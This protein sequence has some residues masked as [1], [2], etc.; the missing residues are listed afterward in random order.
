MNKK[1]PIYGDGRAS[2]YALS[3]IYDPG[4]PLSSMQNIAAPTPRVNSLVI[5]DTIGEHNTLYVVYSVDPETRKCTLVPAKLM[6][7]VD[8]YDNQIVTYGNNIYMLYWRT[9]TM[10]V[11][12]RT[13]DTHARTGK[14]YY[15]RS[16]DAESG[17]TYRKVS[18]YTG[19][20]FSDGEYYE[21][22]S[23]T[24]WQLT[25][26]Q[27]ISVFGTKITQ[28]ALFRGSNLTE[29][30]DRS[31]VSDYYLNDLGQAIQ[32]TRIDFDQVTVQATDGSEEEYTT[33]VKIPKVCYSSSQIENNDVFCLAMY[34]AEGRV[35]AQIALL[36]HDMLSLS[37]LASRQWPI[38][39]FTV[40][41]NQYDPV[42]GKC[43]LVRGQRLDEL[44]FYPQI[45]YAN[46]DSIA[47]AAIDN[48]KLCIY[49]KDEIS[50]AVPGS[51]YKVLLKYYLSNTEGV[52]DADTRD[53]Q[54][55]ETGRFIYTYATVKII[56]A[57]ESSVSK[58]APIPVYNTVTGWEIVPVVYYRSRQ[59]PRCISGTNWLASG[60]DGT[61][62]QN[63]QVLKIRSYEQD[64]DSAIPTEFISSYSMTVYLPTNIQDDPKI[65][66]TFRDDPSMSNRTYGINS[67]SVPRP[68]LIRELDGT[69]AA[70]RHYIPRDV[71][72]NATMFLNAFYYQ[73]DPPVV[74]GE[75]AVR[76]PTHFQIRN[77]L[78]GSGTINVVTP[79]PIP[80]ADYGND[81]AITDDL[82]NSEQIPGTCIV[83][84]L[85]HGTGMAADAY[86]YLYGVPV[87]VIKTIVN[88]Q[89]GDWHD[90]LYC[91]YNG[92]NYILSP[93]GSDDNV[94]Y[95]RTWGNSAI[96]LKA[97]T[98]GTTSFTWALYN[99]SNQLISDGMSN[100]IGLP[101]DKW[102]DPSQV[103]WT[104]S[105]VSYMSRT[106]WPSIG[107]CREKLYIRVKKHNYQ[108]PY[109]GARDAINT[110]RKWA[111]LSDDNL[112]IGT[113]EIGQVPGS[114][115]RWFITITSGMSAGSYYCDQL[116]TGSSVE[117]PAEVTWK[118]DPN[119]T[120][121]SHTKPP[122][123]VVEPDAY[124]EGTKDMALSPEVQL[125]ATITGAQEVI[126][127]T[128][129]NFP[130]GLTVN[131]SSGK[132]TGTPRVSGEFVGTVEVSSTNSNPVTITVHFTINNSSSYRGILYAIINGVK[133]VFSYI[134]ERDAVNQ[135]RLWEDS[136]HQLRIDSIG[137]YDDPEG[138]WGW[139]IFKPD[140]DGIY[141]YK[142]PGVFWETYSV[143]DGNALSLEDL[144]TDPDRGGFYIEGAQ[145]RLTYLDRIEPSDITGPATITIDQTVG[146]QITPT[147]LPHTAGNGETCV[148]TEDP[149]HMLPGGIA[150]SN[151]VL[152]GAV[153]TSGTFTSVIKISA[154]GCPDAQCTVTFN[155]AD[156]IPCHRGPIYVI[157]RSSMTYKRYE[158]AKLNS[159]LPA[160]RTWQASDNTVI[161]Q[162]ND[163]SRY[164]WAFVN[165]AASSSPIIRSTTEMGPSSS[166]EPFEV[167]W[168]SSDLIYI[169]KNPTTIIQAEDTTIN[170]NKNTPIQA[171][172]LTISSSIGFVPPIAF[173]CT[174]VRGPA[175]INITRGG[176]ITGSISADGDQVMTVQ[177]EC[178]VVNIPAKV[179]TVTF[180]YMGGEV[181]QGPYYLYSDACNSKLIYTAAE[182]AVG[183]A[184]TWRDESKAYPSIWGSSSESQSGT[185]YQ[186]YITAPA[187]ESGTD[188][189]FSQPETTQKDPDQ[190]TFSNGYSRYLLLRSPVGINLASRSGGQPSNHY[191]ATTKTLT[192][193][194]GETVQMVATSTNTS[195]LTNSF[196]WPTI[197]PSTTSDPRRQYI[198]VTGDGA[199]T[200]VGGYSGSGDLEVQ[201]YHSQHPYINET[202]KIVI[203]I[204]APGPGTIT[205]EDVSINFT[206]GRQF[207]GQATAVCTNTP[208]S[209][210]WVGNNFPSGITISPSG[211]ISGSSTAINDFT[212][213]A[214]VT[215]TLNGQTS[216][217]TININFIHVEDTTFRGTLYAIVGG[218]ERELLYGANSDTTGFARHW[219]E[220]STGLSEGIGVQ[221]DDTNPN[222]WVVYWG[223]GGP[224]GWTA[225]LSDDAD[226][227]DQ[228]Y[229]NG[230]RVTTYRLQDLI[231][232]PG[233]P[234]ESIAYHPG[235]TLEDTLAAASRT[236][237]VASTNTSLLAN[238]F[239]WSGNLPEGFTINPTTGVI[240][241]S[242]T[243]SSTSSSLTGTITAT[244][245]VHSKVSKSWTIT[246][247]KTTS[248]SSTITCDNPYTIN[249]DTGAAISHTIVANDSG[250]GN[251]LTFEI[252]N[253]K[254]SEITMNQY[255]VV[256]GTFTTTETRTM[257]VRIHSST[258]S[259]QP[260]LD[261]AVWFVYSPTGSDWHGNLYVAGTGFYETMTVPATHSTTV[262]FER[263]WTNANNTA[264]IE[265]N[266][267]S[268]Q[269]VCSYN[270]TEVAWGSQAN[271]QYDPDSANWISEGFVIS[272]TP[273]EG[274]IIRATSSDYSGVSDASSFTYTPDTAGSVIIGFKSGDTN[275]LSHGMTYELL[276][277]PAS[278]SDTFS[279]EN[280]TPTSDRRTNPM[281]LRLN[282]NLADSA[283]DKTL[284]LRV[285]SFDFPYIYKDFTLSFRSDLLAPTSINATSPVTIN[286]APSSTIS[287]QLSATAN[288]PS[289]IRYIA[290]DSIEG[291]TLDENTGQISGRITTTTDQTMRI[292]VAAANRVGSF[293]APAAI[294]VTFHYVS[295]GVFRDPLYVFFNGTEYTLSYQGNIQTTGTSRGWLNMTERLS[296]GY[297]NGNWVLTQEGSP[298]ATATP[299]N[300]TDDPDALTWTNGYHIYRTPQS[301]LL[302][303]SNKTINYND[304][305]S[306]EQSNSSDA[307]RQ[308]NVTHLN[309]SLI[310]NTWSYTSS[311]IPT[312]VTLNASTG[313][314]TGRVSSSTN[315]TFT[316]L[317]TNTSDG[318]IKKT[319]TVTLC[320]SPNGG[321]VIDITPPQTINY[322]SNDSVDASVLASDTAGAPVTLS[323]SGVPSGLTFSSN[324]GSGEISGRLTG[325]SDYTVTI[326]ATRGW[327][328]GQQTATTTVTFHNV[329]EPII[330]ETNYSDITF[331]RKGSSN[332]YTLTYVPG[333]DW[334][335]NH[336]IARR[337]W[338]ANPSTQEYYELYGQNVAM[339]GDCV[340]TLEHGG[341]VDD[342]KQGG[343]ID[344]TTAPCDSP[345]GPPDA[346][347]PDTTFEFI[348]WIAH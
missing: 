190:T 184:R 245:T 29:A 319:C 315:I 338:F 51:E 181:Y 213:T 276:T 147:V 60:F 299:V 281:I 314:I 12:E 236:A 243:G 46:G 36:A 182:T 303:F 188:I 119:V 269:W 347:W 225:A 39:S 20:S 1:V 302:T 76:T 341:W 221:K 101:G 328:G 65:L 35:V 267:G 98:S 179:I 160:E 114:G 219:E 242:Y 70:I 337:W 96:K 308:V 166:L 102:R 116:L 250:S 336:P 77:P 239:T 135:N 326:T 197:Q 63:P 74:D 301:S 241:G 58:I 271:R 162:V 88:S 327:P 223:S 332:I 322:E 142:E 121:V 158:Y 277:S 167:D 172:E 231:S 174:K 132:I 344:A 22:I 134:G 229:T 288:Q 323:A 176:V 260:Y 8:L 16:G 106:P 18:V 48:T 227:Y 171:T 278:G 45:R 202:I 32:T 240:T 345:T 199:I 161:K 289:T 210:T 34:D 47:D 110:R 84:F 80:I 201:V 42:D 148:F 75:N 254:P 175:G 285:K 52:A 173:I 195:A 69:T 185:V 118:D 55:G 270:G 342:T 38:E 297:T 198:H 109:D 207:S 5:D 90:V 177:I 290:I 33:N 157:D 56:A 124:V 149:D 10:D 212:L 180:K 251:T 324:G 108:C 275:K 26:D 30:G 296:L 312:G 159:T 100:A 287:H 19:F 92:F 209:I 66:Y 170:F 266:T 50:T 257:N 311:N 27:K 348:R 72:L 117:C 144:T 62:Y 85:Y 113:I 143:I 334:D 112:R 200:A 78:A 339:D 218:I 217:E 137:G 265:Y 263:V 145:G 153:P 130:S 123:S 295:D 41:A 49:G 259:G 73:A 53:Y 186:W 107:D 235:Y 232:G 169:S 44:T 247:V 151:G 37:E 111:I 215:A 57:S 282:Y 164:W 313:I 224:Q 191:D 120:W 146:V 187:A 59:M 220:A 140:D 128:K 305:Y 40:S 79:N 83:E 165:N 316:V 17:Y 300:T 262:G 94:D 14:I 93:T 54:I 214:T 136:V 31:L 237:T 64:P 261:V 279:I 280:L 206:P 193:S 189:W 91:T 325:T 283:T 86:E 71:F 256:G 335:G 150:L 268:S 273:L 104:G 203:N 253:G 97:K 286:Y 87:D 329:D 43:F 309:G 211:A 125:V 284:V 89:V 194:V 115:F 274:N 11:Y 152:T 255:G 3:E 238:S 346:E 95:N 340:W 205:A 127:Y 333:S 155:I 156:I 129:Y 204:P 208:E 320:K 81:L 183:Y 99:A 216:T 15:T 61:D 4:R 233:I 126:R 222:V 2:V 139:H 249:F 13:T 163:A 244:S 133:H 105:N 154:P 343:G 178:S 226:P 21:R 234:N 168:N 68:R 291:I 331:Q 321:A 141:K 138:N 246:F 196:S 25:I 306:L 230:Y 6:N 258:A 24:L 82:S 28:F 294:I 293:I 330:P 103:G 122:V 9:T 317:A 292:N 252:L 304:G 272:K 310:P 23:K 67:V 248:W 7:D 192:L 131:S 307:A 298:L 318:N 228:T 264:R